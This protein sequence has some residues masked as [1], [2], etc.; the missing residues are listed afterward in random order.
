MEAINYCS[1]VSLLEMTDFEGFLRNRFNCWPLSPYLDTAQVLRV[2][3][4]QNFPLRSDRMF[5]GWREDQ[6][7]HCFYINRITIGVDSNFWLV[8]FVAIVW[9]KLPILS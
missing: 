8:N 5:L 7:A 4:T 3:N 9:K 1:A 2:Q 6:D